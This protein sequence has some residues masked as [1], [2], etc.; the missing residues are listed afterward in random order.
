MVI[1]E[2]DMAPHQE[3]N[4]QE[5]IEV[6]NI[7]KDKKDKVCCLEKVLEECEILVYKNKILQNTESEIRVRDLIKE[8]SKDLIGEIMKAEKENGEISCGRFCEI[9]QKKIDDEKKN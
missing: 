4:I 9:L 8:A 6:T 1:K 5:D 7:V 2:T 3:E